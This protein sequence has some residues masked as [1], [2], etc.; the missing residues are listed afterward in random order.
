MLVTDAFTPFMLSSNMQ[1]INDT[2]Y[3]ILDNIAHFVVSTD[4]LILF[5]IS[6][7]IE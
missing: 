2:R 1:M 6:M 5:E 3:Y 7:E 4:R